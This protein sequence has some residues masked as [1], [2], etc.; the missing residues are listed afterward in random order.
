MHIRPRARPYRGS[1]APPSPAVL[2]VRKAAA[3]R[4]KQRIERYWRLAPLARMSRLKL[5]CYIKKH[6]YH[7]D[8]RMVRLS[9]RQ[10][11]RIAS[12]LEKGLFSYE[13]CSKD[14]LRL[15]CA[16]RRIAI[17][18]TDP[19]HL[20]CGTL[21]K[22][23][24]SATFEKFMDLPPELRVLIFDFH[25]DWL[26]DHLDE[27]DII[28]EAYRPPP[29]TR[30]CKL[31]RKEALPLFQDRQVLT[32]T[33]DYQHYPG[34]EPTYVGSRHMP[35]T[36][37]LPS[38]KS[39]RRIHVTLYYFQINR[40]APTGIAAASYWITMNKER[41]EVDVSPFEC[42]EAAENMNQPVEMWKKT[43]EKFRIC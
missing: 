42:K 2:A 8:L 29:I 6:G 41:D 31:I 3:K 39:I 13:R 25:L 36:L 10:L 20:L 11:R 32:L 12:R 15:F 40:L 35:V 24:A 27:K 5:L 1:F 28:G 4:E 21:H 22:A 33:Y 14:S 23:D 9:L 19:K 26:T 43:E 16:S 7:T 17:E 18:S 37:R 34:S 30:A 38:L